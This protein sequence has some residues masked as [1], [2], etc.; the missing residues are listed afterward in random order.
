MA[1]LQRL[2]RQVY[3]LLMPPQKHLAQLRSVPALASLF[4]AAIRTRVPAGQTL[5]LSGIGAGGVVAHEM[6][7]QLQRAGEQVGMACQL[8]VGVVSVAALHSCAPSFCIWPGHLHDYSHA[9]IA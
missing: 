1:A 4:L 7:V 5:V 9:L 8:P 3:L 2:Q 6:A